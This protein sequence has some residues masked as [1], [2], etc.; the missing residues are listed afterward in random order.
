MI[1]TCRVRQFSQN[2]QLVRFR[3]PTGITEALKAGV[4]VALFVLQSR[5]WE[6]CRPIDFKINYYVVIHFAQFGFF[7][8]KIFCIWEAKT[9]KGNEITPFVISKQHKWHELWGHWTPPVM[10]CL[11]S[12]ARR[13]KLVSGICPMTYV[14][15]VVTRFCGTKVF[16]VPVPGSIH[17]KLRSVKKD[18][19]QQKL[20][21]NFLVAFL[22]NEFCHHE[23]TSGRGWMILFTN[24]LR[25]SSM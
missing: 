12:V 6:I 16:I 17:G 7:E 19:I 2:Q 5:L 20:N 14:W 13:M 9:S 3:D 10:F 23:M 22:R 11:Y 18:W 15:K 25:L 8:Y 4:D 24:C 21:R 1:R